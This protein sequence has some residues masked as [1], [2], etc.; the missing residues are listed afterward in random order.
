MKP[1]NQSPATVS[2]E[3]GKSEDFEEA[4]DEFAHDGGEGEFAGLPWARR[5]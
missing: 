5:R 4:D 1:P 2:I 3:Q